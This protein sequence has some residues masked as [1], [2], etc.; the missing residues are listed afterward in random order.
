M[1][2]NCSSKYTLL[3]TVGQRIVWNFVC[4]FCIHVTRHSNVNRVQIKYIFLISRHVIGPF[5]E[6]SSGNAVTVNAE[7]YNQIRGLCLS[8]CLWERDGWFLLSARCHAIKIC[9]SDTSQ[10]IFRKINQGS[11]MLIGLPVYKIS[12]R[13]D[14]FRWVHLHCK[15]IILETWMT[16]RQTFELRY[17]W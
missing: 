16:S 2:H 4:H 15:R 12:L 14:F 5:Y 6:D 10:Q 3:H 9:Y 1:H 7:R 13:L 11:G 8:Y 17:I